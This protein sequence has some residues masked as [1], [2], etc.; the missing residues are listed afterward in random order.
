M[1]KT[2]TPADGIAWVTGASSGIGREVAAQLVVA[3]WTVAISARR[4]EALQSLAAE[5]PGKMI[6]APLDIT[7]EPS[8]RAAIAK[9]TAES[10]RPIV[11]AVLNAGIYIRD[12]A[13]DFS[14][15]AFNSQMDVNLLG[16]AN[17]LAA[18][19]PGMM[20]ARRGQ[21]AI[22]GS[23]AGLNGLPGAVTY[24][25]TKAALISMAQSLKF[26]LDKAG[27]A[28][29]VVLP[30]FVKTPATAGNSYDMPYLMEVADAA[31]D[32]LN[33]MASGKF[34]IAFPWQLAWPLRFL[35]LLPSPLYF[36]A[37]A[38]ATKW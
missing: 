21:I 35:R 15:V 8:V 13:P 28:I 14:I 11:R 3:G 2:P 18:L 5:H 16:T 1:N 36:W 23:V 22:I 31:K 33:G 34:L 7:D 30:G 6:V 20:A 26:D 32:I 9:I 37:M 29:C 17:C 27:V 10:G 25:A 38:K 24:S 4:A 12:T 19:M